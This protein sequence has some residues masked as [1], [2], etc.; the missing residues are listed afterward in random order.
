MGGLGGGVAI[1]HG[2]MT[3]KMRGPWQYM[4]ICTHKILVTPTHNEK[5][6]E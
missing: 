2:E 1:I 6:A 4:A 3:L 5:Q